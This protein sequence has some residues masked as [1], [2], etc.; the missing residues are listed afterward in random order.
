M[1]KVVKPAIFVVSLAALCA[2]MYHGTSESADCPVVLA[3]FK[4]EEIAIRQNGG[5]TVLDNPT[6]QW[7]SDCRFRISGDLLVERAGFASLEKPSI[8]L[9]FDHTTRRWR[10]E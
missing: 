3:I 4:A 1:P 2:V 5:G 6:A 9:S 7:L 10:E 8:T